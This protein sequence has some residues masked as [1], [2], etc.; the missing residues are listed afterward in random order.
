MCSLIAPELQGVLE[1]E[2]QVLIIKG[3]PFLT[4]GADGE[5]SDD[6]MPRLPPVGPPS[7]DSNVV[8]I[9]PSRNLSRPDG[10][11]EPEEPQSTVSSLWLPPRSDVRSDIE[12]GL[13]F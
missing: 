11:E 1:V 13:R 8:C 6:Q 5:F 4:D 12:V 7:W 9:Q 10:L 2:I 3:F